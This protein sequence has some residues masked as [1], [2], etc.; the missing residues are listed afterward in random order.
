M[1]IYSLT[2]AHPSSCGSIAHSYVE[3]SD[4]MD[5]NTPQAVICWRCKTYVTSV[6][7]LRVW[8]SSTATG[9]R[10]LRMADLQRIFEVKERK[11]GLGR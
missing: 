8:T 10:Q 2:Q 3:A 4:E 11:P 6:P 1:A 9:A 7:G 5:T